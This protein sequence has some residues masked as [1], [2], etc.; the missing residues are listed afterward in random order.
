HFVS[1]KSVFIGV[2]PWLLCCNGY[3]LGSSLMRML[4]KLTVPWSPW[5]K[6]GPGSFT[7]LSIS[8]PVGLLHS[9]LSWILTP[10][11]M[12]VMRSPI[13]VAS[14]VCHSPAGLVTNLS[15]ALKL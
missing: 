2:H 12:T 1:D 6:I 13:M 8:L 9:T 3:G 15:G 7:L 11:M 10:F 4:R 14:A 5:R